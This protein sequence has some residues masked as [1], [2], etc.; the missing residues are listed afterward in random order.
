[1]KCFNFFTNKLK[2]NAI[3]ILVLGKQEL[4]KSIYL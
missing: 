4:G 3:N 2:I 1:M